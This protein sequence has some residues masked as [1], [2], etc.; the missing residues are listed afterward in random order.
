MGR[1]IRR[2]VIG[3][4]A[5][6]A[7]YAATVGVGGGLALA[8]ALTPGLV[9]WSQSRQPVPKDPLE[10]NYRGDPKTALGLDYETVHYD[11]DFGPSEAWL[12]PGAKPSR[13]WAVFVHGIGGLR[14]NG[15]RQLWPSW[16]RC[17]PA[18]QPSR[19]HHQELP[20]P[21]DVIVG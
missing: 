7:L 15:Y 18:S 8:V 3:A 9:D 20:Q 12:V 11:A 19:V 13:T 6:V 2:I 14:E 4:V 16:L 1:W 5:A 10:I 21:V 17:L